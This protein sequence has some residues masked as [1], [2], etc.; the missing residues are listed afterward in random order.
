LA[1]GCFHI[2][3]GDGLG[4]GDHAYKKVLK[5]LFSSG[6]TQWLFAR[7]HPNFGIGL[8][9]AWSRRSRIQ[10]GDADAKY[11]ARRVAAG[12]LPRA[13]SAPAPRLLVFGH[14]HLPLDVPWARQPLS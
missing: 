6:L 12:V 10:N 14:R 13:G 9:N 7:L 3:H 11:L 4:P 5:P 1:R 8:A 2:G